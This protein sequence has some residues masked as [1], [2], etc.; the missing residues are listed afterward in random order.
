MWMAGISHRFGF[1]PNLWYVLIIHFEHI[2][3][4]A[5]LNNFDIA[6]RFGMG[7]HVLMVFPHQLRDFGKVCI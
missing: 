6:V 5:E 1:F 3:Q 4:S 7:K 2:Y